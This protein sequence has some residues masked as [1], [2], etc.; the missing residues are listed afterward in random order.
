VALGVH[1]LR[2]YWTHRRLPQ[3]HTMEFDGELF[4]VGETSIA[5]H[6]TAARSTRTLICVPGFLEDVRYFLS[7]YRDRGYELILIGN[8][9][10]YSPFVPNAVETLSWESNP[11]SPGSIEYDAFFVAQAVQ[12]LATT[13]DVV[14]HG[15]SRGGAVV[16]DA[17]RQFPD[18]TKQVSAVLEAPVLPQGTP[19][20]GV[21]GPVVQALL[22]YL[23]PLFFAASRN[24]SK[25]RLEKMPMMKPTNDRKT[26][27][28][29]TLFC[30]TKDYATCLENVRDIGEWQKTQLHD[31]YENFARITV[32]VGQ[33][34]DVLSTKTMTASAME[35]AKRNP[36]VSIVQTAG[37]NH[38]ISLETPD[39]LYE[40]LGE[41]IPSAPDH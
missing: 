17:G 10:Y 22:R 39:V 5:V 30:N 36:R 2:Q 31:L 11:H 37:T 20:G 24:I 7:L 41:V 40:T 6:R 23:M 8:A 38:F 27:F 13:D 1:L 28:L 18:V 29:R 14:L 33:R 26:S 25:K 15:H 34:D 21:P 3:V 9:N 32:L 19:A 4:E 35:G 12:S 16:L